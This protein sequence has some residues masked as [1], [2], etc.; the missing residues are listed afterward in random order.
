MSRKKSRL[1][2]RVSRDLPLPSDQD[3]KGGDG[4]APAKQGRIMQKYDEVA[5]R[6]IQK[7]AD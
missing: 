7:I 5:G 4:K 3:V 2:G 1:T 6:L